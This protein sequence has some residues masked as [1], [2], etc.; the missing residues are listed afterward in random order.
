MENNQNNQQLE[1]KLD[2]AK[3]GFDS[4]FNNPQFE[5]MKQQLSQEDKDKYAAI[6]KAMYEEIDYET[7]TY[8]N[9][10]SF[11]K[12]ALIYIIEGI[13]SGLHPSMLTNDEIN[14]LKEA[15][16]NEWYTNFGFKKEDLT[17]SDFSSE[18]K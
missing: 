12:D 13:K 6:G 4:L 15:Y 10:P 16:G 5:A 1:L 7:S 2:L 17:S 11:L 9:L 8:L 18:N 14:V 3:A